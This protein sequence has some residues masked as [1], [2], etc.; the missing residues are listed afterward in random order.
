MPKPKKR[1]IYLFI[2][3]LVTL[4]IVI[5]IIPVLTGALTRTEVLRYGDLKVEEQVVCY[6]V[7]DETVYAAPS[8]G[9]LKFKVEEG[10]LIKRSSKVLDFTKTD[11]GEKNQTSKYQKIMSRL[12]DGLVVDNHFTAAIRGI[13]STYIDGYEAVFTPKKM[14]KLTYKEVSKMSIK[15][16]DVART[17]T[18]KGE[19]IYKISD[20]AIWYMI[21]WI[22]KGEVS[23]YETGDSVTVSLPDGDVKATISKLVTDEDHFMVILKTNRYYK[24]F[25][26][27]RK[28]EAD[29]LLVN[30]SG[31]LVSNSALTTKDGTVGV[32]IKNT[33]GEYEFKPVRTIATDGKHTIVQQEVY[34]NDKGLPVET[35][36]VYDEVLKNPEANK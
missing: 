15:E 4:Y 35:V 10:A 5:E 16:L 20:N 21:F 9:N 12:G 34:Y 14:A 3:A 6:I 31:L 24:G 30:Q 1:T 33:L 2:L 17:T 22:E 27:E 8:S 13:F 32:Y 11:E 36:R 26:S 19:P 29:V 7:R 18:Q 25:A 28:V 23:K